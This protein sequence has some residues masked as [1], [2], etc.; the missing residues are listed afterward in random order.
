MLKKGEKY[1]KI[2]FF[3]LITIFIVLLIY[4]LTPLYESRAA[5]PVIAVLAIAFF[6]LGIV[7]VVLT[8][9]LKIKKRLKFFLLLTG[10]SSTGFLVG[11]ILH[12]LLYALATII[13]ENQII[14]KTA[15]E[16][17]H[18]GFFLIS[19]PVCPI[20]FIVGVIGAIILFKKRKK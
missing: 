11:S 18:V 7:L 6:L 8:I 4:F 20:A 12:N 2:I 9:K 16:V 10:A 19:I 5:F 3:S 15:V 14:L 13:N 1:L 17:L